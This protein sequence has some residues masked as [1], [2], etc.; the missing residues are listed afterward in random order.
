MPRPWRTASQCAL[1]ATTCAYLAK[2]ICVEVGNPSSFAHTDFLRLVRT[3]PP[4]P[5]A[6]RCTCSRTFV[7]IM[8]NLEYLA[9]IDMDQEFVRANAYPIL[10]AAVAHAMRRSQIALIPPAVVCRS[11]FWIYTREGGDPALAEGAFMRGGA[12]SACAGVLV[13]PP[14]L[15]QRLRRGEHIASISD[16]FG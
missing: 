14:E 5:A 11:S 3:M 12:F 15:T 8:Q 6:N 1:P 13:V 4:S 9:M 2:A 16:V 7:G 10:R